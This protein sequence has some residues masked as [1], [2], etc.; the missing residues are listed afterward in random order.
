MTARGEKVGTVIKFAQEGY[1]AKTWEG[2]IVRGGM[3]G[4]SGSFSITP[5][6]FTVMD[7]SL[8]PKVQAAFD[9]QKEVVVTYEQHAILFTFTSEC[10]DG[11]KFLT[12]IR[13]R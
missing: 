4:G 3:N 12:S 2:E 9:S 13:E 7:E 11:C 6:H 5:L 10:T 1:F 8:I